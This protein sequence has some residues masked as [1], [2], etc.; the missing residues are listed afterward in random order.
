MKYYYNAKGFYF[1]QII[2]KIALPLGPIIALSFPE[3]KDPDI[4]FKIIVG[5]SKINI[6]SID[7]SCF[8]QI[9]YKNWNESFSLAFYILNNRRLLSTFLAP[10]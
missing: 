10:R 5:F 2:Y 6:N 7:D 4:F 1:S 8:L 3:L 9:K